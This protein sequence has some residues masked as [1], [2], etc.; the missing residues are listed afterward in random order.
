MGDG[1]RLQQQVD[2]GIDEG[3]ER[4]VDRRGFLRTLV[5]RGAVVA[6]GAASVSAAGAMLADHAGA[7]AT[8]INIDDLTN[9]GTAIT[10]LT[11]SQLNLVNGSAVRSLTAT[12]SGASAIA[13]EATA[14]AGA[15]MRIVPDASPFTMPPTTG[16]WQAGSTRV[17]VNGDLWYCYGDGAG[18]ASGWYPL[19]LVPAFIPLVSPQRIYDSRPG[20]N[21]LAVTKGKLTPNVERDIDATFGGFVDTTAFAVLLNFTITGTTAGGFMG[22]R[23]TGTVFAGAS[24]INWF[25]AG[26]SLAN[27]ATTGLDPSGFFTVR[28]GGSAAH[29]LCDVIGFYTLTA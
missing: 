18:V 5:G 27:N 24:S 13:I 2:Q 3:G 19:S 22:V 15:G 17:D 28:G 6:A 10:R 12:H 29:F 20:Q 9:A 25:G 23:P 8:P 1:Q 16:T 11:G 14:P 26:Q 4:P 21:P 7:V